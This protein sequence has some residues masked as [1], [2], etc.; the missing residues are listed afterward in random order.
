MNGNRRLGQMP[1][2]ARAVDDTSKVSH[3]SRFRVLRSTVNVIGL[4][5]IRR[6]LA[7]HCCVL[8]TAGRT[9]AK[10]MLAFSV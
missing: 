8:S 4:A 2:N 1:S 3:D 6:T 10:E 7:N 5:D 9:V